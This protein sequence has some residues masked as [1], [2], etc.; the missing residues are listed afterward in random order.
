MDPVNNPFSPGAGS[1]PPEL[2]GR[3]QVLEQAR[4]LFGRIKQGRSEKSMLLT[5]LRGVGKTV[6]LNSMKRL[7]EQ[8]GYQTIMLEAH[9][10]KALGPMLV[11]YLRT[12]LFALN[13][14]AGA[15]DK[16]RRCWAVFKSFLSS[17]RITVDEVT[18]GFDIDPE[19]GSADS[20]DLEI[21]LSNLF[22]AIGEAAVD[23]KKAVAILIDEIQYLTKIE[24]SALIMAMHKMQQYQ[25][26]IVLLGAGL[27]VLHELAGDSK[28]Y[29]ERLFN[30][31]Q[32]G[33][34]SESD[35]AKALQDPMQ[36]AGIQFEAAA[37]QEI[38]RITRGYPYFLQEWG[39]QIW[40]LV[41]TKIVPLQLVETATQ[42]AIERLD[43]SFFQVRFDR[44]TPGEKR[45]L[46]VM[47]EL[48]PGPHRT[49]DIA[50]GLGIQVASI[51]PLRAKL[52]QKGM[53]YS[54]SHGDMAFTV[55]LFNEFMI[56]AIPD[57][58]SIARLGEVHRA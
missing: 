32:I 8:S 21:D 55:P 30:F 15:S 58:R 22:I 35:A 23:R 31:L 56:R 10:N 45:F 4:I 33:E 2:V 51:S 46:R 13:R 41:D 18:F 42:R 3:D 11:P 49:A 48:G 19:Q 1:K 39:Y 14:V 52:I 43:G 25:L 20:G 12:I 24:L 16:M 6:L 38:L 37:M 47:A 29:A 9:E 36:H 57:I 40:N 26:P 54:P 17:L 34:L 7:A 28:S 50:E 27:P 44:L 5:G 53:I